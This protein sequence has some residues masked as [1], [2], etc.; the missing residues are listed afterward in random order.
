MN[1]VAT[2]RRAKQVSR[3][4]KLA[5]TRAD[6]MPE[7]TNAERWA[8][9]DA[10]GESSRLHSEAADLLSAL[11]MWLMKLAVGFQVAALLFA[12]IGYF[13]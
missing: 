7:S 3:A 2:Y 9:Y 1:P 11:S 4:A 8:K 13:T 6:A 5:S 12:L 10:L